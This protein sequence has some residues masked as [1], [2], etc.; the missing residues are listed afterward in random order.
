[1]KNDGRDFF[2]YAV[3]V[4]VACMKEEQPKGEVEPEAAAEYIRE[5]LSLVFSYSGIDFLV[6]PMRYPRCAKI[7]II[8]TLIGFDKVLLWYYPRMSPGQLAM[9]LESVL[10]SVLADVLDTTSCEEVVAV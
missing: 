9:E 1:M 10:H 6:S 7:P 4:A 5:I 8:I 3:A 2:K